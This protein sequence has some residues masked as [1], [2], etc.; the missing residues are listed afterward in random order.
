MALILLAEKDPKF[1]SN[2]QKEFVSA[3]HEVVTALSQEE[4]LRLLPS[5]SYEVVV[6]GMDIVREGDMD[7]INYVKQAQ[8]L[9]EILI[10]TAIDEIESAVRALRRMSAP[11]S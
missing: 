6:L 9:C 4:T 10:L 1:C 7:L 3:G 11:R 2:I 8:P 5:R